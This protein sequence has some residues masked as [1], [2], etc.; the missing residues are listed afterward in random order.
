MLARVSIGRLV[1]DEELDRMSEDRIREL[2]RRGE[3][4]VLVAELTFEELVHGG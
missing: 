3:R 2:G 4:L 1:G